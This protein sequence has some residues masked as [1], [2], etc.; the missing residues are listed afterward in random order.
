MAG[1][2]LVATGTYGFDAA[3]NMTSLTYSQGGNTWPV[4]HGLMT[5]R[6]HDPIEQH[7][8]RHR[9]HTYDP[10][11]QFTGASSLPSA[12]R[13]LP[14]TYDANGNRTNTG[15]VTGADNELLSDGTYNYSYDANGN[16]VSRS[17]L[18]TMRRS[19]TP[20]TS[21]TVWSR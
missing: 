9:Q 20:M 5:P 18:P 1:T 6:K 4:I 16:L 17:R 2:E 12:G 8:R 3:G 14:N 13:T 7:L 10:T 21:A 19:T 15:D 11:N